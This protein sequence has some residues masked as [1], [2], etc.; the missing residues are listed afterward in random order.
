[1]TS[2]GFISEKLYGYVWQLSPDP[3]KLAI[4]RSIHF[5]EPHGANTK[6]LYRI[7]RRHELRLNRAYG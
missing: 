6:I 4:E 2:V 5:H 7:A 1:M 3:H